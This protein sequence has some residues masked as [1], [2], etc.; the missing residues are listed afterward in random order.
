MEADAAEAEGQAAA[1]NRRNDGKM[2]KAKK[3]IE[4]FI[5]LLKEIF[6]SGLVS[7]IGYGSIADGKYMH[8]QS[9]INLIVVIDNFRAADIIQ[10]RKRLARHA[11]RNAITP[12]FFSPDFLKGSADVFPMEWREIRENH[13]IFYGTDLTGNISVDNKNLRLQIE[14]ELKQNYI[15]FQQGLVFSRDIS[16]VLED[17]CRSLKVIMRSIRDIFP[18]VTEEPGYAE[19]LENLL[20]GRTRIGKT[21][22]TEIAESHLSFMNELVRR[23]DRVQQ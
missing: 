15:N 22:L 5:M 19:K 4:N 14:R 12:F 18:G 6:G 11:T 17:S 1:G 7:V 10:T 23:I 13:V 8:G 3:K 2:E 20:S 16:A 9:D 21:E